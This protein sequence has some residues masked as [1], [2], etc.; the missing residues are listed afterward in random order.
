MGMFTH[1]HNFI[2]IMPGMNAVGCKV[3]FSS[4]NHHLVSEAMYCRYGAVYK[5]KICDHYSRLIVLL[6][7]Y[8]ALHSSYHFGHTYTK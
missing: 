6:A 5:V 3:S 1:T 8:A 2:I 4:N 7:T